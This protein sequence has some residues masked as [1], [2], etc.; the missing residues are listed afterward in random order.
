MSDELECGLGTCVEAGRR[1]L[2]A[3]NRAPAD[4]CTWKTLDY[5]CNL[6][7]Q[8]TR[9]RDP[10]G[11]LAFSLFVG[12]ENYVNICK[13]F[14]YMSYALWYRTSSVL[15]G[16][17]H[18]RALELV[19]LLQVCMK[20]FTANKVIYRKSVLILPLRAK[21]RVGALLRPRPRHSRPQGFKPCVHRRSPSSLV[22][23]T[24]GQMSF[25]RLLH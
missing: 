14:Y 10:D 16:T 9:P 11:A 12:G 1:H 19:S 18:L 2:L 15:L 17:S 5:V 7:S 21:L 3:L 23:G 13:G 8:S 24:K 25:S 22:A 4:N 6:C 20:I